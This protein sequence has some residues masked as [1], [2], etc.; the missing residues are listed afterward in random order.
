[1][2]NLK[3]HVGVVG[4]GTMGRGIVQLFAQAGHPIS[5]FDGIEGAVPKAIASVLEL[6]D[7]G[8]E[9][10]IFGPDQGSAI[11]ASIRPCTA[12]EQEA[13]SPL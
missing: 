12:L 7:N 13:M 11:K 1:M 6:I 9:R 8:V 5:V 10:K 3:M 2:S 4:A